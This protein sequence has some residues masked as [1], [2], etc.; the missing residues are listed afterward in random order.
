M[1]GPVPLNLPHNII[2]STNTELVAFTEH[3]PSEFNRKPRSLDDVR[4]FQRCKDACEK[5]ATE[6]R[7]FLL[8]LGPV[9]L[10]KIKSDYLAY[11]NNLSVLRFQF[12]YY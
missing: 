3:I 5:K 12:A 8:Y 1:F 2:N 6:F 4:R 9:V 7:L 11:Y 10:F